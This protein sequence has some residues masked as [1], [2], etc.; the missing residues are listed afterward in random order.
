MLRLALFCTLP[1][2]LSA[3]APLGWP[4]GSVRHRYYDTPNGQLHYVIG[5]DV[6]SSNRIPM[7]LLHSH[8]RSTTEFRY[9]AADMNPQIPFLAIDYFGMGYSDDYKGDG[10]NDTFCTFEAIA[11]HALEIATKE[12]ADKFIVVGHLKGAHPAIELAYQAT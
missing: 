3:V 2:L 6:S 5:G 1:Y 8:P 10:A 12:G 11:S 9:F 7:L 4:T